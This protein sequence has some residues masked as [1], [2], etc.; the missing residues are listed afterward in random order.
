MNKQMYTLDQ[1]AEI[2]KVEKWYLMRI[3]D[4]IAELG[5]YGTLDVK[6]EVRNGKVDRLYTYKGKSYLKPKE[7]PKPTESE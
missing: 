4:S 6:L 5:S 2:M 3:E 7:K 1:F